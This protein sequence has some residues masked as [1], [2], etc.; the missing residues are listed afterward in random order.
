[1]ESARTPTPTYAAPTRNLP[2][3][4]ALLLVFV[5]LLLVFVA[6][7]AYTAIVAVDHG[8]IGFLEAAV[9]NTAV[10]QVSLDRVISLGIA[11]TFVAGDARR[12]GLPFVPYLIATLSLGSIGLLAYMLHRTWRGVPTQTQ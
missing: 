6:F 11:L 2:L 3:F 4:V 9:D 12:R 10:A 5:A 7:V 1:M 8:P